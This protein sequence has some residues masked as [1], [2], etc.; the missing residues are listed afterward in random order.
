MENQVY[1]V[2]RRRVGTKIE[3]TLRD[4]P[5]VK[6]TGATADEAE[7]ELCDLICDKYGDGEP[8]FD[9][10]DAKASVPKETLW[11]FRANEG[12]TTL[13]LPEL[14]TDGVCKHC[15][16]GLGA[17]RSDA[18]RVLKEKLKGDVASTD[19]GPLLN[20]IFSKKM[21]LSLVKLGLK[22]VNFAPAIDAR[23]AQCYE[24]VD[25]AAKFEWAPIVAKRAI[26]IGAK[27][28]PKCGL[29][30]F[31]YVDH[32][33]KDIRR[34]LPAEYFTRNPGEVFVVSSVEPEPVLSSRSRDEIRKQKDLRGFVWGRVGL[35]Q[36]D[37]IDSKLK[38][39]VFPKVRA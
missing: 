10:F 37:E 39:D 29:R 18:I 35:A 23:G 16:A 5:K 27:K 4:D 6:A 24:L 2:S 14:F 15:G 31:S 34:F 7:D 9:Y 11:V 25:L 12:V 22:N 36:P 13:N 20:R 26:R 21:M 33:E 32:I 38:Y 28:C 3:L 30:R 1:R 19:S 8:V 17:R